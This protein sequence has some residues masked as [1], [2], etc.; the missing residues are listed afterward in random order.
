MWGVGS[1]LQWD[2]T[3][4]FYIGVEG[5]YENMKS[6]SVNP[7]GVIPFGTA[8]SL[9]FGCAVAHRAERQQLHDQR[10]HAQGLPALIV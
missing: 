9:S 2:V 1:R 6:A 3:K 8:G 4:S 10:S 7:T 5:L